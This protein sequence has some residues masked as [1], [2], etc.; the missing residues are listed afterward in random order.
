[1]NYVTSKIAL[2]KA[3]LRDDLFVASL[4]LINRPNWRRYELCL[5]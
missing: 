1:M 2:N 4:L 5:V 3:K